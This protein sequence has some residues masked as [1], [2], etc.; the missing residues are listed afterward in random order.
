[1]II[2]ILGEFSPTWVAG[3]EVRGCELLLSESVQAYKKEMPKFMQ[4][5]V[6]KPK[7]GVKDS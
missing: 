2:I 7:A 3:P 5:P 1:M 4:R 6:A